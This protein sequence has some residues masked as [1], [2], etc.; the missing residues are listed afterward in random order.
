MVQ[1][2]DIRGRP[3]TSSRP[4]QSCCS[5]WAAVWSML[6]M[7]Y[8]WSDA[9]SLCFRCVVS[10]VQVLD[11]R[12]RPTASTRPRL[13]DLA[14]VWSM[15]L[16]CYLWSDAWSL[17]FRCVVSMVQ[18]LDIRGRP[19]TSTRPR[20]SCCSTWPL[21][22]PCVVNM[23]RLCNISARYCTTLFFRCMLILRFECNHEIKYTQIF[24]MAHHENFICIE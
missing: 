15:L 11:I 5:T 7:C 22:T 13:F 10:M 24:G 23:R 3:T 2:L 9:W 4:R 18:V 16:M 6:L 12:G 1:V 17:C 14:A 21:L 19:T 8:L 20:Q